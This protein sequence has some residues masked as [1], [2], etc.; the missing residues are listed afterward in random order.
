MVWETLVTWRI[1]KQSVV[2][3]S[4]AEAELRALAQGTRELIWLKTLLEELKCL[5]YPL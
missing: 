1:K 5:T 2:A 4:I 3:R